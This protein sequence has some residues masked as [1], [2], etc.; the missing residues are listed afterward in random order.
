MLKK[1]VEAMPTIWDFVVD[2]DKAEGDG[3]VHDI[4][5]HGAEVRNRVVSMKLNLRGDGLLG[6]DRDFAG[7]IW[8]VLG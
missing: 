7:V 1:I 4:K 8:V 5:G 2:V 3:V 6:V